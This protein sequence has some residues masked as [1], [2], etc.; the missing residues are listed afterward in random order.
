[1]SDDFVNQLTLNFLIS[2]NQLQKLNKKIR[3]NT[4]TNRRTD[5]EVY[6]ERITKLFQD[7]LV[8]QQPEDLLEDVKSGFDLFIDKTI[9]YFKA[10]D[11]HEL[12]ENERSS[13]HN[14]DG[15]DIQDDIDFEKEERAIEKGNYK[16]EVYE[17]GDD[18][19]EDEDEDEER[20]LKEDLEEN[21]ED[22]PRPWKSYNETPYT[23]VN[24]TQKWAKNHNT[25]SVGVDDIQKLPL[26]WFQN[27]KQQNN[28]NRIIPRRKDDIN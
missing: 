4:D 21:L 14:Y 19:D 25:H 2:K 16:E 26:D 10:K 15:R 6:S 1:M 13:E 11:N 5:K 20:D 28:Q 17:Y 8:N 18:V 7:L 12:L 3:E 9:Y 23:P 24:V 22:E 27:V